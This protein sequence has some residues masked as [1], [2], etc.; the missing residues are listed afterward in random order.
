M[1][2]IKIIDKS[3][4]LAHG[5]KARSINQRVM[6]K[7]IDECASSNIKYLKK[8]KLTI[9]SLWIRLNINLLSVIWL[10]LKT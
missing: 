3:E 8:I 4:F 2:V 9:S 10:V 1:I 7:L 5:M 6:L